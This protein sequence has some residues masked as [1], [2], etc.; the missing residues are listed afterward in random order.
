MWECPTLI[1]HSALASESPHTLA[2]SLDMRVP[3]LPLHSA[4]MWECPHS[5][6]LSLDVRVSPFSCTRIDVRVSPFPCTQ[7]WCESV[8]LPLLSA[9]MW[10]CPPFPC[11]QPWRK[12]VSTY[13]CIQQASI[14]KLEAFYCIRSTAREEHRRVVYKLSSI[15]HTCQMDCH[16]DKR[17]L[18]LSF[19]VNSFR[20]LE[21]HFNCLPKVEP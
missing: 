17:E 3:P 13:P 11:T 14:K 4:L 2:L 1:F 12:V 9:L 18:H 15:Q 21:A 6:A 16:R 20:L 10:E 7:P 19:P 8:P 5:L